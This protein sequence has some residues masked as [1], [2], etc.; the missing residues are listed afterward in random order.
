M[1]VMFFASQDKMGSFCRG[2]CT[3]FIPTNKS[4]TDDTHNII[5]KCTPTNLCG[6]VKKHASNKM[7]E[8]KNNNKYFS[9][10]QTDTNSL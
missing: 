9:R 3:L 6:Q 10:S 7:L 8:N 5:Q 2:P 1:S 4:T